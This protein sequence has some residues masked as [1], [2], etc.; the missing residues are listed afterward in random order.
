[1]RKIIKEGYYYGALIYA[2][3]IPFN[4]NLATLSLITWG[5]LSIINFKKSNINNNWHWAILPV[6]Y[7]L[8]FIGFFSADKIYFRF[9][10]TKLSFIIFPL[11]FV[12]HNYTVCQRMKIL[13]ILVFGIFSSS[14]ICILYALFRST[15]LIDQTIVFAANVESGRDFMESVLYGGNYFFGRHLSI[16]HQTV[17]FALYICTGISVLLFMPKLFLIRL[18]LFLIIFFI[19]MLFLISNK[20]S[21]IATAGIFLIYLTTLNIPKTKKLIG[22]TII[23]GLIALFVYTNPR[24]KESINKVVQGEL[25]IDKNARYGFGTRILSWDAALT[26]IK[27]NPIY[28]YGAGDTQLKLNSMYEKKEYKHPLNKSFNAHNQWFQSWL[29]NGI[30]AVIALVYIFYL[31]LT[32]AFKSSTNRGFYFA[33]FLILFIN[34][35]FE[36]MFD[37]FSGVSFMSFVICFIL[38][39]IKVDVLKK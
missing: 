31:L 5:L 13:K 11:I 29:E 18:R 14:L 35:L 21:F 39:E 25:K 2:F 19:M 8:Y 15:N 22:L 33:L 3:L 34:T 17:Y 10:E 38:S 26:L 9:L 12:L 37:R 1:M 7:F 36:S 32:S 20:A 23:C 4:Q 28:G 16:F 27:E 30:I 24:A 6:F